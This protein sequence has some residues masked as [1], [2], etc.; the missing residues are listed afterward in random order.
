MIKNELDALQADCQQKAKN[1]KTA[2]ESM[3]IN[4][5]SIWILKNYLGCIQEAETSTKK[6]ISYLETPTSNPVI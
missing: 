4:S 1:L 6:L 5:S 2:T 3:L